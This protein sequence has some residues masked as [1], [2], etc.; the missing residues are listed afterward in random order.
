MRIWSF[1]LGVAFWMSL[2]LGSA[3]SSAAIRKTN[4]LSTG[5]IYRWVENYRVKASKGA[6]E[7]SRRQTLKPFR[8]QLIKEIQKRSADSEETRYLL[9]RVLVQVNYILKYDCHRSKELIK[10][11]MSDGNPWTSAAKQRDREAR[12]ALYFHQSVCR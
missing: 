5:Q 8:A 2:I 4:S 1:L 11:G 10:E 7:N 3:L 6:T 9:K 12:E